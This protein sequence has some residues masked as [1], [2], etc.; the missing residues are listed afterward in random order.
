MMK[1][2]LFLGTVL[3]GMAALATVLPPTQAAAQVTMRNVMHSD[4]KILDPIWT[5]AYIQ[6][7][8]GY[9]IYDTLF[10][11]DE[12]FVVKPQMVDTWT[13]SDDKITY[14]FTLRDG[15]LWHDDKPV[16]A[17]DCV[18]SLKRWGARDTMGQKLLGAVKE[19]QVVDDKTFKLIL[20]EPYGL[21][22]ESLGKPSSNVPFMMPKRVAETDPLTQITESIGSGPFVFK[23]DE[24]KPG[25]KAVFVKFAKYKPRA[26]PPSGLSGGKAV[27]IDRIEWLAIP[28]VQTAVN[29]LIAGEV[30]YV[31]QPTHDM[32]PVLKKEKGIALIDWNPVGNQYTFRFNTLHPPFNNEKIRHAAEVALNQE[33]FLK[34]VIGDP[35]YYKVCKAMFVCGTPFETMKGTEGILDSNFAKAKEELKAAGYDGTPVLLMHSTDLPVLTNL[36]PVAADLLRKGGFTVDMQSMDWQTLVARRSKKEPPAQGGW[37]A[38][39]TSWVAAD[40]LNPVMVGFLNASCD[41]AMFGWPCDEQIE[42]LRDAFAKEGDPAKQKALVEQVQERAYQYGTHVPLGQWYQPAAIRKELVSGF[43]TAP[44]P[45]FWNVTKK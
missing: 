9:M 32:F 17:E 26:E 6:R 12:K 13:V 29:A 31:E 44:A 37:N 3:A 28:D 30:D 45:V 43:L 36:G 42:K 35:N 40:I 27:K 25:D 33:D 10:A 41:K 21:V 23:R 39:M 16:T 24:W 20:K 19:F 18:A 1:R 7:N 11:I 34:A 2:S 14:T 38:F 4:L 5:T 15:L 8:Y 22:L